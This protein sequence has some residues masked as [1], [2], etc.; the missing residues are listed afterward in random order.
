MRLQEF[1]RLI[2][3]HRLRGERTVAACHLV[4]VDGLLPIDA[5]EAAGIHRSAVS[6]ALARLRRPTCPTCGRSG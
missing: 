6:R 5:A 4:L 3:I 2:A 1:N